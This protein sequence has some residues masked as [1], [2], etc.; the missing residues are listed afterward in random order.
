MERPEV[1]AFVKYYL[2]AEATSLVGEV[3][4]VGLPQEILELSWKRFD[5]KIFGSV[6]G[7]GGSKS[8]MT[9]KDLLAQEGGK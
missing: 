8:G 7:G 2:S 1:N 9:M 3:G 4:Y 5:G 6:F